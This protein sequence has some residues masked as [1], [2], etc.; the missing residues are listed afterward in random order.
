MKPNATNN[1]QPATR[2]LRDHL[3]GMR[4]T[5][6]PEII[7]NG[8]YCNFAILMVQSSSKSFWQ[9]PGGQTANIILIKQ[10]IGQSE[11]NPY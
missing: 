8:P 6:T 2:S 3:E 9:I 7:D 10:F 11:K 1:A 5:K 4:F